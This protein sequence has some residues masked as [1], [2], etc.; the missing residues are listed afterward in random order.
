M[1]TITIDDS[2]AG[3]RLDEALTLSGAESSRTKVKLLFSS[4]DGVLV[5]GKKEKPHYKVETGDV[6]QFGE[7]L[8]KETT[9]KAEELPLDIVYEDDDIL[10][11]NKR[12][13]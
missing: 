9:I 6:I 7:L 5:N 12:S 3:K 11:I 10:V 4:S 1:R 2:I 8:K 13:S